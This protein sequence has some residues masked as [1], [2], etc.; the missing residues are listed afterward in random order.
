MLAKKHILC[1]EFLNFLLFSPSRGEFSSFVFQFILEC[2]ADKMFT[3]I[4]GV[5]IL[6]FLTLIEFSCS[7]ILQYQP[8]HVHLSLGGELRMQELRIFTI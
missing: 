6:C 4:T 8:Q 2:T 7:D 3:K 1:G 5:K